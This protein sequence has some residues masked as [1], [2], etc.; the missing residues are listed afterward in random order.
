MTPKGA[1]NVI[2]SK[3]EDSCGSVHFFI[4][5]ISTDER[6]LELFKFIKESGDYVDYEKALTFMNV[7]YED[8][9]WPKKVLNIIRG[10]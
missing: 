7:Y 6:Y 5:L 9:T 2:D 8:P 3:F 4:N 1:S 10:L